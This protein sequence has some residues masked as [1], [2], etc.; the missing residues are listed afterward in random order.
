MPSCQHDRAVAVS[1]K[2]ERPGVVHMLPQELLIA[3]LSLSP[4]HCCQYKG[5]A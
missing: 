5:Y 2:P 4:C 1:H 3:G